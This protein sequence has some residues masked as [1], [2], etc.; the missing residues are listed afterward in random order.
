MHGMLNMASML[1]IKHAGYKR[2]CT[3]FW[4]KQGDVSLLMEQK[5]GPAV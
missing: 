3:C 5:Q 4:Y 2:G 1:P